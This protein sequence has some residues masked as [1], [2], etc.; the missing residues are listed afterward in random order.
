MTAVADLDGVLSVVRR[1]WSAGGAWTRAKSSALAASHS[2]FHPSAVIFAPIMLRIVGLMPHPWP[3]QSPAAQVFTA[4]PCKCP[5]GSVVP[6]QTFEGGDWAG[7]EPCCAS[8]QALLIWHI[9]LSLCEITAEHWN[10]WSSTW[11]TWPP[12]ATWP[13]CTPE[14]WPWCG[15][16]I[17]SGTVEI[18][19]I[20][21]TMQSSKGSGSI[22]AW[23]PIT[24]GKCKK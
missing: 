6:L 19:L 13:T 8:K 9:F 3:P 21:S 24:W 2:L 7:S 22:W 4:I 5:M 17:S 18:P 10:T 16:Q 12:S 14:T 23:W 20:Q 11:L 15:L 1:R